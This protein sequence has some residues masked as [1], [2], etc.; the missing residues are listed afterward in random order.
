M[1]SV[2]AGWQLSGR[3][4]Q[5]GW[6]GPSLPQ[7]EW[8]TRGLSSPGP[9]HKGLGYAGEWEGVERKLRATRGK[10]RLF[11]K[12]SALLGEGPGLGFPAW[13][14]AQLWLGSVEL[15]G[16]FLSLS[17][18]S[19]SSALVSVPS[20]L[21]S[22][23]LPPDRHSRG[24]AGTAPPLWAPWPKTLLSCCKSVTSGLLLA[25]CVAPRSPLGFPDLSAKGLGASPGSS[26]M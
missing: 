21:D 13:A 12:A 19:V 17:E 22:L 24:C 11:P 10:A 16:N 5:R 25:S 4:V 2:G 20:P 26:D 9:L 7:D 8:T 18:S 14:Q 23:P 3:R 6:H 1:G 15:R